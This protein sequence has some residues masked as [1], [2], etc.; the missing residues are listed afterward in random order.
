[1]REAI[2]R[3]ITVHDE[4]SPADAALVDQGLDAHNEAAAPLH[5]VRPLGCFA[6]QADGSVI[7][8]ALGRTWGECAELQQLWVDAAFRRRGHGAALVRRFERAALTRGCRRCYLYTFSFQAPEL[9]RALG[10][11]AQMQID[12]FAPGI[13]K[14]TMVRELS[15]GG[16]DALRSNIRNGWPAS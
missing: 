8:G 1:M 9:Y 3:T 2:Q 12:G 14:F 15:A 4:P 6:R 13:T 5:E 16:D 11:V 7:G 10:Y